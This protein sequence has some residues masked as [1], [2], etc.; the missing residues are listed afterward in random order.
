[1]FLSISTSSALFSGVFIFPRVGLFMALFSG[2]PLALAQVAYH[3]YQL[4]LGAMVISGLVVEILSHSPIGLLFYL[5]W[6]GLSGVL[7]G[8]LIRRHRTFSYSISAVSLQIAAFSSFILSFFYFRTNGKIL[9]EMKKG[10]Y[11]TFDQVFHLYL[12]N[13]PT[14]LSLS[15]QKLIQQMEPGLFLS[16]LSIFPGMLL[17]LVFLTSLVLIGMVEG[18]LSRKLPLS[19]SHGIEK[20]LL[21][22]PF[23]FILILTLVLIAIPNHYSRVAGINLFLGLGTLYVGQGAG[24][25][26]SYA[27]SRGLGMLFWIVA[28]TFI[29]LQPL[30]L[31]LLGVV[32]VL[33]VWVD[34]RKIRHTTDIHPTMD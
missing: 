5:A 29:L 26:V 22:D 34:F 32:G 2:V 12:Q 31:L 1:M 11:K 28:A 19:A 16:F 30:I 4:G 7:A 13:S 15:D 3:R 6:A 33:D 25:I 20:W 17:S 23:I 14:T 21:W 9:D 10:L 24:V 27:K 8:E 18:V